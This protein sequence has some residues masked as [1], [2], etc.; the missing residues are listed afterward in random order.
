[1]EKVALMKGN[2]D[3][4][5]AANARYIRSFFIDMDGY[6]TRKAAATALAGSGR[7]FHQHCEPA[8]LTLM[9]FVFERR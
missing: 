9:G 2:K 1:M 8:T 7:V 6:A 3:R 4:R 5:I